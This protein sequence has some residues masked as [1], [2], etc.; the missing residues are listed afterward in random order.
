MNKALH[1]F[2]ATELRKAY[3]AGGKQLA[4]LGGSPKRITTP[5][6]FLIQIRTPHK[7]MARDRTVSAGLKL[8][9]RYT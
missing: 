1:L 7:E 5:F 6:I 3:G 8:P 2:A 9:S 4:S